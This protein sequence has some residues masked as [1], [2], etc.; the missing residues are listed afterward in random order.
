[1]AACKAFFR[2]AD[3]F[4]LAINAVVSLAGSQLIPERTV[5]ILGR[6]HVCDCKT[7]GTADDADRL[8]DISS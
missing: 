7:E 6:K 1:M 8:S 2:L 4:T 3:T 5:C